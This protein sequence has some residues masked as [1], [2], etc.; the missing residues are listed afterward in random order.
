MELIGIEKYK[1]NYKKTLITIF[2]FCIVFQ[3]IYNRPPKD[4]DKIDNTIQDF[5][6]KINKSINED[7]G[8]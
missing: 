2:Q 8:E 7:E 1:T 4:K 3:D 6:V 5:L